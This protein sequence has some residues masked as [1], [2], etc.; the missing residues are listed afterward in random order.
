VQQDELERTL[1]H[2]S[3]EELKKALADLKTSGRVQII[4]RLG[5]RFWCASSSM[6]PDDTHSQRTKPSNRHR[7]QSK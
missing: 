7:I 6:Y 2:G 4:E 1:S 5:V 3:L